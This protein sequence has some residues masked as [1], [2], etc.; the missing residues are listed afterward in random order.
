LI[1]KTDINGKLEDLIRICKRTNNYKKIA[2]VGFT[3]LSNQ[4]NEIGMKLG[5]RPRNKDAGET[6]HEYLVKILMFLKTNFQITL[7]DEDYLLKLNKSERLFIKKRGNLP[8]NYISDVFAL[9]YELQKIEIPDLG[10]H[11]SEDTISSLSNIQFYSSVINPS[12]KKGNEDITYKLMIH[13]INKKEKALASKLQ[14]QYDP[15]MFER[16][17]MLKSVK[18]SLENDRSSKISIRGTLKDNLLY[19]NSIPD[20]IGYFLLGIFSILCGIGIVILF[21]IITFPFLASN[22]SLFILLLFVC[23]GLFFYIYWSKFM[24]RGG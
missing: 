2:A 19:K 12:K 20:I 10:K 14:E 24:R 11:I 9:Y 17:I 16:A 4:A 13:Q 21:E 1:S 3:L 18:S 23:A 22:L 6:L 15:N 7:I 8:M 5:M